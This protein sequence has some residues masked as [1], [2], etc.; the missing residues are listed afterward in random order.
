MASGESS[1]KKK[2][3]EPQAEGKPCPS[4]FVPPDVGGRTLPWVPRAGYD[5]EVGEDSHLVKAV[6][7]MYPEG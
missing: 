7:N 2:R 3:R 4:R 6:M 1:R 5:H